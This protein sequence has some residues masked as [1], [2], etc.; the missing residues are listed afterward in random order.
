[1]WRYKNQNRT[2]RE[3]QYPPDNQVKN[4]EIYKINLKTKE[5]ASDDHYANATMEPFNNLVNIDALKNVYTDLLYEYATRPNCDNITD[6]GSK[7]LF[8]H[9]SHGKPECVAKIKIGG[10]CTGFEKE[11]ICMHGYCKNGIC[12]AK[13]NLSTKS[14]IKLT[15]IK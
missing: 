7:Y 3:S 2:E 14:Q 9:R 4:K 11:D 6:C 15:T 1:M 12:L 13:E 5:C 10:N 8:C